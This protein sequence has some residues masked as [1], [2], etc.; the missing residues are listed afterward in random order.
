M[1][2]A[3]VDEMAPVLRDIGIFLTAGRV[4]DPSV[5]LTEGEDAERLGIARVWLSE[6][7]TDPG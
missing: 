3:P 5:A 4:R 1:V 2:T 6:R 7:S